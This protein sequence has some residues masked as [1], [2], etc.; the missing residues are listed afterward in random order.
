M[1]LNV[2]VFPKSGRQEV[3]LDG[4]MYKIYLK[5]DALEG[6][7]N[8]ELVKVLAKYFNVRDFDVVIKSGKSSRK[9]VVEV[10]NGDKL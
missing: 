7:A 9:K 3:V 4:E 10:K 5:N 2:K 6:K 1:I 8:L